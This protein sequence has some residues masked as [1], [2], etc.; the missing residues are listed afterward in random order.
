MILID[1]EN[2]GWR[3]VMDPRE[4]VFEKTSEADE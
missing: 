2:R 4:L 1:Y 3:L